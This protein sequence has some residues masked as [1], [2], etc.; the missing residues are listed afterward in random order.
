LW[1]AALCVAAICV[2]MIVQALTREFGVPEIDLLGLVVRFRGLDDIVAWL[3]ADSAVLALAPMFKHG[4]LVRVTLL[5]DRLKGGTRRAVELFVLAFAVV[6]I[7]YTAYA[8]GRFVHESWALNDVAQGLVKMELWIPQVPMVIGIAALWLAFVED[9]V[10]VLRR[11]QTAYDAAIE[12]RAA[13]RDYSE[14]L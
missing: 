13:R 11:G 4:D 12:E 6:F 14:S 9:F 5:A 10:R 7:G 2:L 3:C 8:F 1:L